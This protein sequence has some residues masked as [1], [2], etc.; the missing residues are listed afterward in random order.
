MIYDIYILLPI[1]SIWISFLHWMP[2]ISSL[3]LRTPSTMFNKNGKPRNSHL[4]RKPQM[5]K[6][7]RMSDSGIFI[8]KWNVSKTQPLH[9]SVR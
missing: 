5:V 7:Q 1:N 8:H 4:Y 2:Y 3:W 9:L 6:L